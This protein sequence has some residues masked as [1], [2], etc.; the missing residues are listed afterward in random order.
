MKDD[1]VVK[2]FKRASPS[3]CLRRQRAFVLQRE[4]QYKLTTTTNAS[5]C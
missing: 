1:Q 5:I 2:L 3:F 4:S